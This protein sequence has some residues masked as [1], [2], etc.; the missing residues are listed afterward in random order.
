MISPD[1]AISRA[2]TIFEIFQRKGWL[3]GE[4]PRVDLKKSFKNFCTIANKLSTEQFEMLS[5]MLRNYTKIEYE[6]Y[7]PSMIIALDQVKLKFSEGTKFRVIPLLAP[8]DV[9]KSKSGAGVLYYFEHIV[10]PRSEV[11]SEYNLSSYTSASKL[12][13]LSGKGA[14]RVT[15]VVDDFI[16]SG[17]TV[18][19]FLDEYEATYL[20][21]NESVIFLSVAAM[22]AGLDY[23]QSRG[24]SIFTDIILPKGIADCEHFPDKDQAYGLMDQLEA[25][26]S[27]EENY[28][29]GYDKSEALV[30]LVRTPNNTFPL[31]WFPRAADGTSWP[32][33]FPR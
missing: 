13:K 1:E 14:A 19:R 22:R 21:Q 4:Q 15:F 29:Y 20:A 16:G 33:P 17:G 31:F 12:P 28:R 11:F 8:N 23:V 2:A 5:I 10:W 6:S 18:K 25:M 26:I 7:V 27:R 3:K 30:T 24:Y 9:G 32:A